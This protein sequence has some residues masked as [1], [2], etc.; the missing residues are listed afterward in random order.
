MARWVELAGFGLA[1][2]GW[3]CAVL[4]RFLPVWN[5]SGT[6]DNN[7]DSLPLY[8]D[9]VWLNWQELSKANLHCNFYMSLLSLTGSFRSWK[10]L[11]VASIGT[12]VFP[13]VGYLVG[14][15][16]F[17]QRLQIKAASGVVFV[18]SGLLLLVVIAWTTHV[19]HSD[20]DVDIH[21]TQDWGP[22]LYSGWTGVVLLLVGGGVLSIFCCKSTSQEQR[23]PERV[24]GSEAA[25]S[26]AAD[27]LFTIHS[28]AFNES[29][30]RRTTSPI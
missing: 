1:G 2:V 18:L 25:G 7:T 17:P 30:Y 8:W 14:L 29:P 19:T 16:K 9:G 6:V 12:G 21:L 15:I 3:L 27:P 28:A 20:L 26:E 22:A 5:V 10:V 11:L 13:A 4:T 24:A 23:E